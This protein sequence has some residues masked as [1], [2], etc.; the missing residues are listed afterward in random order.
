[1]A[2]TI[3][4][5]P[6]T[7][8]TSSNAYTKPQTLIQAEFK[9][10]SDVKNDVLADQMGFASTENVYVDD[11]MLL[12][13]RPPFKFYDRE[14]RIVK[15]WNF[16]PYR[17]RLY[18]S[19][20]ND[21][22][23]YTLRCI[24]HTP[25]VPEGSTDKFAEKIWT[26]PNAEVDVTCIQIKDKIFVWFGGFDLVVFNTVKLYFESGIQYLYLPV[27]SL[28]VNGIETPVES[29]N[30]LTP[31]G[32]KRHQ[33][34]VLSS[35]N[36]DSLFGK[37]VRVNLRGAMT[38]G[39]SQYLYTTTISQNQK[40]V[41]VY[42]YSSVSNEYH[43]DMK[44]GLETLVFLRY[45][46]TLGTIEI[47][48]D[49]IIFDTLPHLDKILGLPQLTDDARHVV[50]FTNK[51]VAWCKL[52]ADKSD[53][54]AYDF[55][56][57]WNI[58]PYGELSDYVG[59]LTIFTPS[60]HFTNET[61]FAYIYI[62]DDSP[63]Y[64]VLYAEWPSRTSEQHFGVK[65][66]LSDG[67]TPVELITNED[68]KVGECFIPP[69]DGY[70]EGL[71]VS[72]LNAKG[73]DRTGI[74]GKPEIISCLFLHGDVSVFH[75]VISTPMSQINNLAI[76]CRQCDIRVEAIES[77][78]YRTCAAV[79][80][81]AGDCFYTIK[82]EGSSAAEFIG[83]IAD[84]L[85]TNKS[86]TQLRINGLMVLTDTYYY[87]YED[88]GQ[89]I[90]NRRLID[91]P[92][93]DSPQINKVVTNNDKVVL[94]NY[95]GNI[96]LVEKNP[97]AYLPNNWY[98]SSGQIK[99][100]SLVAWKKNARTT[101]EYLSPN[102]ID[103]SSKTATE[104]TFFYIERVSPTSD[105]WQV[106]QGGDI[107][108]GDIVRLR[109]YP[110]EYGF[111]AFV[112]GNP[113]ETTL[114]ILP[115]E[116]PARGD[117]AWATLPKPWIST[118]DG[119]YREWEEDKDPLPTGPVIFYGK[120][121]INRE[122][123]PLYFNENGIWLNVSGTL[124]TSEPSADNIL[125][126]DEYV[127]QTGSQGIDT[128]LYIPTH[129]N[130]LSEHYFSFEVDGKHLLEVA[131]TKYNE[132][133]LF[134]DDTSEYL[135]YLPKRNEQVFANKITNL[136]PIADNILAVFTEHAI[137]NITASTLNDGAVAYSAPILSKIPAGCRDGDDVMTALD[138]QALLLAT[139]R[140]IAALAPQDFVATADNIMTYLSDPIQNTY[141]R[142]YI[143]KVK[144]YLKDD[145]YDSQIKMLSYRYWLLFYRYMDREILVFDT[146]TSA[147]WKW[148]TPYPIRQIIDDVHL[149]LILQIDYSANDTLDGVSY[150]WKDHEDTE[151]TGTVK[152]DIELPSNV[153]SRK[154]YCDDIIT[155]TL[156]GIYTVVRDNEFVDPRR[157]KEYASPVIKWHFM[158]QKLHFNQINNYKAI[159]GITAVL[160]G[161]DK[162]QAVLSTKIYRDWYHPEQ[163]DTVEISI[164]ELKTFTHR[165]NL[166]HTINFQYKFENDTTL[167][168][169]IPLCLGSLSIKYE[170]KEGI[171]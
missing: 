47:S 96:H 87:W 154:G 126:L 119:T 155:N 151:Y 116:Y 153:K 133:K 24:S 111:D 124:W 13:S 97:A 42:P 109:A 152:A 36:F 34:S 105:G 38:E 156:S 115:W 30:F 167:E 138:G 44:Q 113:L 10:L 117:A 136:H 83:N 8:S 2:R 12:V 15:H 3:K 6:F 7:V 143:D 35:V 33:Y 63:V 28:V 91:L 146:R 39:S 43:I 62:P 69:T 86:S 114:K 41:L 32:R 95:F 121:G 135:L 71:L 160:K 170:V 4:R 85:L 164:N 110:T 25:I 77:G 21:E 79:S 132:D 75:N 14:A 74:D 123:L 76:S 161:E 89:F 102:I 67:E 165:L 59:I 137:W 139:S 112:P 104:G 159:K 106:H 122:I 148:S 64:P 40:E 49:G 20:S 37:S 128:R 53:E 129:H 150:I 55:S 120:V 23:K 142:F 50:A 101:P 149:H 130:E 145:G 5:Q 82:W 90:S 45:S 134:T 31:T 65:T 147:W 84:K 127:N 88:N 73:I 118:G 19:K 162:M 57:V 103:K 108:V 107:R 29:E 11:N 52:F 157:V 9:G 100:G 144:N 46:E 163:S 16:G 54:S 158:S 166:M 1:M 26:I 140:G 68:I 171:R 98:L 66:M 48:F 18:R 60:G 27:L 70:N 61:Q 58:K 92:I 131:Q 80:T 93:T 56:F 17:L 125:E 81:N 94:G 72:I 51:G 99:S 141:Y 78:M 168:E 22:F 169:Q